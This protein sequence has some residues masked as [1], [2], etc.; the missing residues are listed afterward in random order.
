M[1]VT[2]YQSR[3][4]TY[5]RVDEWVSGRDGRPARF[6]KKLIPTREQA[7]A[8]A[9]KV[10]AEAFEGAFFDRKHLSNFTVQDAWKAYEPKAMR[11]NDAYQT[12]KGRATH[13]L[14][15]LG[16]KRVSKLGVVDVE[17]YRT[18]RLAE[19]TQRNTP[20]TAGTLDRE[21]ELLKRVLNYAVDR[22]DIALNPIA[23]VKL[24]RKPNVRRTVIDEEAFQR[25]FEASEEALRPILLVAFDTGMREREVLDLR[26]EQVNL[27]EGVIRL[28]PQDTKSEDARVIVLTQRVRTMLESLPRGLPGTAV[29][30]NPNTGK[31]WQEIRKLFYRACAKAELENL[32]FH[33]LRRSF[34]TR[35]RKLG[36]AESVVMRMSGHKTRAVFDRYNVVNEDDLRA[37]AGRLSAAADTEGDSRAQG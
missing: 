7:M 27:K 10:K 14:R 8:L 17:E 18:R 32:W 22:G 16:G 20:P 6:R 33:D 23:R 1:G 21:V 35:A 9:A 30:P 11:D 29:L 19:K 13:L 34:V 12:D 28:Q 2:K 5:W 15:H 24:L 25:L 31:P 3:G 26:W 4:K 36:I 37:A